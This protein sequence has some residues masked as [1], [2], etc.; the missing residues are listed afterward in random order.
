MT[1]KSERVKLNINH[2][3]DK[4][5]VFW[6]LKGKKFKQ[7]GKNLGELWHKVGYWWVSYEC[8]N[9][10]ILLAKWQGF[11][12]EVGVGNERKLLKLG[13]WGSTKQRNFHLLIQ[14]I[15]F[16]NSFNQQ[17]C[18]EHLLYVRLYLGVGDIARSHFHIQLEN[19]KIL[20]EK[21]STTAWFCNSKYN[22]S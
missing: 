2:T 3:V 10:P 14:F 13:E 12:R 4:K 9:F 5:G 16:I 15:S 6:P 1:Q 18:T 7:S 17:I 22:R 21:Y 11:G 20:G 19:I 8:I